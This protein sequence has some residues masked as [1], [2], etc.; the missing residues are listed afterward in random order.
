M[1][2]GFFTAPIEALP[3]LSVTDIVRY[4]LI[5][6]WVCLRV[7]VDSTSPTN[8]VP[9]SACTDSAY[10]GA[11]F[12]LLSSA[13]S[14][15]NIKAGVGCSIIQAYFWESPLYSYSFSWKRPILNVH[16]GNKI[17]LCWLERLQRR[18]QPQLPVMR[19]TQLT[20][21]RLMSLY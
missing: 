1:L 4:F 11:I 17:W 14:S 21:N 20:I 12:L 16:H 18:M 6:L 8:A 13:G 10:S 9:T 3:E 15:L 7:N 5:V 19:I 2:I